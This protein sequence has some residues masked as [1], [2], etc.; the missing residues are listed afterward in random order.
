METIRQ[1][2]YSKF[3][4]LP[5]EILPIAGA[6]SA[7]RYFRVKGAVDCIATIGTSRRE[8]EA[9]IYLDRHFAELNLPVPQLLAVSEDRMTYLQENLGNESLYSLLKSDRIEGLMTDT[10]QSLVRFHFEGPG[11]LDFDKC[12]PRSDMDRRA[13][14]WDL[15][16]FKYCFLKAT[17]LE[18][19]EDLLEN[20][21]RNL[22]ER[23]TRNPYRTLMLRDCQSRNIFIKDGRPYFIDFQG[24]RRGPGAYDVASLLWQAR[25]D[26]TEDFRLKFSTLYCQLSKLNYGADIRVDDILWQALF[27]TLQTLGAYGF[28]GYFERKSMFLSP[29][30]KSVEILRSL[31]KR[32]PSEGL[33]Y[34]FD[35]LNR[36]V[37]LP[38]FNSTE[39]GEGLTVRVMSFSYK[40]G[41]PE[42]PSGNGGGFVFDCR[43]VHN[44][45][46]YDQYKPLTGMDKEV[47]DFLESNPEMPRFMEGCYNLVDPAVRRY[48]ERGFNNL[49]VCFGCTGG[50][51]RSVYGAEHLARHI[52]EK[53]NCRVKVEHRERQ[54]NY[55][56]EPKPLK[57]M[58]FAAGLGT[59]LRPLTDSIPKA[60]VEV[61]GKP[62]LQ[63]A[64]EQIM[65]AGIRNIVI[66]VH[67]HADKVRQ[68]LESTD[69][70]ANIQISDE[71][72]LLLDTGGGLAKATELLGLD[73]N[74]LLYNADICCDLDLHQLVSA[75]LKT[76][77]DATLLVSGRESSRYLL[78]DDESNMKGW[79]NTKNG[80]FRP[81]DSKDES[82]RRLA[83]GGIHVVSPSVLKSLKG[84]ADKNGPVFS[85]TNCY[86]DWCRQ[87][88]IKGFESPDQY[89]WNDIGS[90][91]KLEAARRSFP[92]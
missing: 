40:Q 50:R 15:N 32:L 26:F 52:H 8:N 56:L 66:N 81:S 37:D 21:F 47:I 34:L 54:I 49:M 33:T 44:P 43:A 60:M 78:F 20:D 25:A 46:R 22:I 70:D 2:Y 30:Q 1:L 14:G 51:H 91:E 4:T 17:G 48:I 39:E 88:T 42:D 87:M 9:F 69:F 83:F 6:G 75:H 73:S 35:A 58:I 64:I 55:V 23:V 77:A 28:R 89:R 38:R 19:D 90:P 67:H 63:R 53:L 57:A 72:G 79:T 29:I 59:R 36:M 24:A 82:L 65:K 5:E 31:L 86:I 41:I 74:V 18:F 3:Q 68:F 71:S 16:Y 27:R 62:V 10:I 11:N 76:G 84:Y 12:Y 80:E 92:E 7:R 61:G 45:G 13:A 85:I